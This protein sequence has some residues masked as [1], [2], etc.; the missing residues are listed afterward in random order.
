[1]INKKL[2]E[3]ELD[4]QNLLVSDIFALEGYT[5]GEGFTESFWDKKTI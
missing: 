1:M 3:P 2:L 4:P 5:Q